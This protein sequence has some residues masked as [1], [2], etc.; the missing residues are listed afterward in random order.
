MGA[1]AK[2][3]TE[4]AERLGLIG[5]PSFAV[6]GPGT[7]G[8]QVVEGL[9]KIRQPSSIAPALDGAIDEAAG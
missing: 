9:E 2:A 4:E 8:L 7:D 6:K 5:T 3:S 1:Q